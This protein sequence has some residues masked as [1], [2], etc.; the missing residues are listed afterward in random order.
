LSNSPAAAHER[1]LVAESEQDAQGAWQ[2]KHSEPW[3]NV[4]VT[5]ES[6]QAPL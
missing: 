3:R 6:M 4:P 1:Q 5:Q 2:S